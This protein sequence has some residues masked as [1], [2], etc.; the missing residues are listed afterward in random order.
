LFYPD[1]G[2]GQASWAEITSPRG[3]LTKPA[4]PT[5]KKVNKAEELT[6]LSIN[7]GDTYTL[8][9][10]LD[11]ILISKTGGYPSRSPYWT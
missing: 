11:Q 3:K 2:G 8:I 9:L 6:Y 1:P 10:N 7:I 5:T 4:C